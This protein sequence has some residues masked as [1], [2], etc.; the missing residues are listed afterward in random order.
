MKE[1]LSW[2]PPIPSSFS[3]ILPILQNLT[4]VLS[5]GYSTIF[6]QHSSASVIYCCGVFLIAYMY[7]IVNPWM[8]GT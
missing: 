4:D 7:S 6:L 2:D 8:A 1:I 3:D 5:S